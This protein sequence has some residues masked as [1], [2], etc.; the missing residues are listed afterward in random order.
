MLQHKFFLSQQNCNLNVQQLYCN[1]KFLCHNNIMNCKPTLL[2]HR[3]LCHGN[4]MHFVCKTHVAKIFYVATFLKLQ[5]L[6]FMLRRKILLLRQNFLCLILKI[7][8][9]I[10]S[11]LR[12]N[13]SPG[14][15]NVCRNQRLFMLQQITCK[16]KTPML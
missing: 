16:F 1:T 14:V 6:K 9:T 11:M 3:N 2:Q 10:N 12:R 13:D 4:L 5:H 15:P 8:T 7:V